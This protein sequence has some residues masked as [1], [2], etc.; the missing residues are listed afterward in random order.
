MLHLCM[1]CAGQR[2]YLCNTVDLIAEKFNPQN[3]VTA[4]RRIYLQHIPA[5][6][7][8][9][10]VK[11][12]IIA[13]VLDI[14]QLADHVVPILDHT[15]AQRYHH[16]HIVIRTTDTVNTRYG[17]HNNN[18]PPF[19]QR[20]SRRKAQLID[21]IIDCRILFNI[22]VR[23]WHISLRLIVIIIRNKVFYRIFREELLK[24]SI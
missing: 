11:I 8:T 18:I 14:D 19:R 9:A 24:L 6:A 23:L 20:G 12:Q 21:L 2:I 1:H 13:V 7:E 4:L 16:V 22:S 17:C 10:A 5:H 3:I 15:R